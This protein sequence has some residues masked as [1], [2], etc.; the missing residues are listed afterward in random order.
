MSLSII[1]ALVILLS[2]G[3]AL[4]LLRRVGLREVMLLLGDALLPLG[5][6]TRSDQER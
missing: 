4:G 1:E 6:D 2:L 3:V 5:G